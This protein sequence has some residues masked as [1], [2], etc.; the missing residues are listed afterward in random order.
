MPTTMRSRGIY[1]PQPDRISRLAGLCSAHIRPILKAEIDQ[2]RMLTEAVEL[3]AH[4]DQGADLPFKVVAAAKAH[5]RPGIG[6]HGQAGLRPILELTGDEPHDARQ[7]LLELEHGGEGVTI[8]ATASL[9][10][11]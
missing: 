8:D 2:L 4:G 3:A 11:L 6:D 7:E 9:N 10:R 1:R 5:A